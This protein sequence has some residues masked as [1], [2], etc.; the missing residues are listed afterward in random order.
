MKKQL[1]VIAVLTAASQI[2]AFFKLWFTARIFGVG[3]ELDG[4]NLALVLP[5]L[6]SGIVAGFLQT[7][8]FPVR[9]KL[10]VAGNPADVDAFERA[11]LWGIASVGVVFTILLSLGSPAIVPVLAGRAPATVI[12]AMGT[13]FPYL[14]IL[15][16]L[17]MAGADR[18][19]DRW[20]ITACVLASGRTYELGFGNS[21][22]SRCPGWHLLMGAQVC[23]IALERPV[24]R[25]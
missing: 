5:T 1:A 2:S 20:W 10:K 7:G 6:I 4:Y 17:N 15:V 3:S 22:R 12:V 18:K 23:R 14:T 25:R 13:A 8:L 24:S 21:P 11:V 19:W 9:A 16:A